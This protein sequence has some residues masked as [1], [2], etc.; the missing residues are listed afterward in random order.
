[1][2]IIFEAIEK[3][4]IEKISNNTISNIEDFLGYS[5]SEIDIDDLEDKIAEVLFQMPEEEILK[6]ARKY[7]IL[8]PLRWLVKGI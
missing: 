7:N 1:M 3:I 5:I 2:S 6:Y 8:K 4:L